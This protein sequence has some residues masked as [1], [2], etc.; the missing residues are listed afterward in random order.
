MG[1]DTMWDYDTSAITQR[2]MP[3]IYMRGYRP[4]CQAWNHGLALLMREHYMANIHIYIYVRHIFVIVT[5]RGMAI[6]GN[7]LQK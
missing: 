4:M 2:Y 7:M 5:G 1:F 3:I 6:G